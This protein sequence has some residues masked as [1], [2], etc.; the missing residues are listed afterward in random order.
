MKSKQLLIL[1]ITCG[2]IIGI[3]LW[4]SSGRKGD[5]PDSPEADN[6]A[7]FADF[8]PEEVGSFTIK[9]SKGETTIAREGASWVVPSRDKFPAN[10]RTVAE[11]L[12]NTGALHVSVYEDFDKEALA[13]S[14]LFP[15]G[16]GKE[17]ESGTLISMAKPGGGELLSFVAGATISGSSAGVMDISGAPKAQWIKVAGGDRIAKVKDGFSDLKSEPKD[18]LDKE[19]FFKIEKHKSI[20]VT[21]PTPEESWKVF[22]EAD[23]GELKLD[24]PQAGEEFDPAKAASQGSVFGYVTFDD[25]LPEAEK[26]K[27]ALDKPTHTAVIETFEG[28]TYTIKV[29]AKAAAPPP[30]AEPDAAN[31]PPAPAESYY[32]GFTVTG[33]YSESPPPYATPAPA[34]PTA[35]TAPAAD[36]TDEDK[37]KY[38]EA[39]KAHETAVKTHE[40]AMKSWEDGKKAAEETFK[41][42][43]EKKKEKLAAEQALQTRI[44]VVQKYT[45]DPI[46]KKRSEFMKEKPATPAAGTAPPNGTPV[47]PPANPASVVPQVNPAAT[48]PKPTGKIEAVT[49]PIE[50]TIPPKDGDKPKEEPKQPAKGEDDKKPE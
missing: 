40:T 11:L 12:N 36:A 4:K 20:A 2:A 44:F 18:W 10:M 48:P 49:P 43:L 23:A 32:V 13:S 39:K 7:L 16:E 9:T 37:K 38:E 31:P 22:R 33:Q 34:A 26:E 15:P 3:A 8:N 50:V 24:A 45:L 46:M 1:L 25:I 5:Q 30:P 21:G 14:K 27:A 29:G 42:D 47:N 35:P 28:L 17:S 41:K 19:K 6:P